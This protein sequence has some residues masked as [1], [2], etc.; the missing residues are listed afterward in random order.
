MLGHFTSKDAL[1][2]RQ[3]LQM[4]VKAFSLAIFYLT[5]PIGEKD[6]VTRFYTSITRLPIKWAIP[7]SRNCAGLKLATSSNGGRTWTESASNPILK[8]EPEY[9][10]VIGFRDPFLAE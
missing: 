5:G 1:S 6:Q 2:S 3:T 7:Y 8:S 4:T 9:L 10:A